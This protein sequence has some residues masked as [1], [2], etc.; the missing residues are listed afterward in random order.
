MRGATVSFRPSQQDTAISIHAPHAGCDPSA[1]SSLLL[2][3]LFQSTHPMRGATKSAVLAAACEYYFNPRTPC[4]VRRLLWRK[5][6]Q[7]GNFNPRTPCGVRPVG[8]GV[9]EVVDIFQ[10]THPVRGA[11]TFWKSQR[12]QAKNFNPRTPCGVRQ[13]CVVLAVIEHLISIHAPRAGCDLC[14]Y[15]PRGQCNHFNP[16]T[17]C[18]VRRGVMM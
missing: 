9:N 16:R 15:N 2:L 6:A 14:L 10:S 11:T 18:G 17:P 13:L 7:R 4:G 8:A 1:V 3:R 12:R 5:Q